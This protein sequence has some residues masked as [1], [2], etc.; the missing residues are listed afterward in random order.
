LSRL[1]VVWS[2]GMGTGHAR[3]PLGS[4]GKPLEGWVF[5]APTA[6]GHVEP[7]TVKKQHAKTFKAL[8]KLEAA[9]NQ[10]PVPPF[11]L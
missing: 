3:N 5:K 9:N 4:R 2:G 10:K 8:A 6:N 11:V 1:G 7:G